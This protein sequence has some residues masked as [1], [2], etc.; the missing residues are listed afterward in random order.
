M[1]DSHY[2]GERISY[3]DALCTVRYIGEVAG[4]TGAWLGVEWD[5]G[6]R[7]KHDGSHKGL[8]RPPGTSES[9]TAA[10]FVRPTRPADARVSFVA[11]LKAKYVEEESEASGVPDSQI[12]FA[13][14]IAEEVGF[15]KVRRQMAQLDELKMAI[16]DGVHM[17]LAHQAG[18]PTVAQVSPKLA[19]ID[20]S[21]NLFEDLGPVVDICKD[22][23]GLKKLAINFT[24]VSDL[25]SL[26]S[27]TALRNVYLKGNNIRT[28]SSEETPCP[29]FP[30]SLQYIDLSYNQ[31]EGWDFI[32]SLSTHF[33]G[34]TALRISHNPVYD[35]RAAHNAPTATAD[36]AHMFT[37]ARIGPLQTLNFSQVTANDRSNAEMFYLGRIAKQLAAVPEAAAATVLVEHPRYEALCELYGAP[38]VVRAHEV[39]PTFLE[40]RLVTLALRCAGRADRTARIPRASDV[41]TVKARVARLYGLS[42]LRLRLVWETGEWDP[43]ARRGGDGDGDTSDEEDDDEVVAIRVGE[44]AT[45][46]TYGE[47][48][49]DAQPGRWVKREVE[50]R[51]GPR[52]LGYWVDGLE[53][54]VRVEPL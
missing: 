42:P 23:P 30:K 49:A 7:G 51:D 39:N 52:Q 34:L 33:P 22:L 53:A 29:V 3:D 14:K 20:I 4:A 15:D 25:A 28:L 36:E 21:R 19:H 38:D 31:V 24:T 18:E 16:L 11:A 8:I 40:A 46:D 44:G 1:A 45:E 54:K 41:Y 2:P 12:R 43:V 10:S 27:L 37:I 13:G 6:T 50:L 35:V 26:T 9:P 17:A 5:D 32:D 47:K 48:L